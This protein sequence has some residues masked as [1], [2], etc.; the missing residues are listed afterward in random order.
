MY[1]ITIIMFRHMPASNKNPFSHIS[2]LLISITCQLYTVVWSEHVPALIMK[3]GL[4]EVWNVYC[5]NKVWVK[6][7]SDV[8][9]KCLLRMPDAVCTNV[10]QDEKC[11]NRSFK[12]KSYILIKTQADNMYAPT[13]PLQYQIYSS[14][15]LQFNCIEKQVTYT[16]TR[17][18]HIAHIHNM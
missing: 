17:N 12:I 9:G 3:R 13:T 14:T 10:W 18:Y 4:M 7:V 2:I 1:I 16:T 8:K 6:S 5:I 11:L 15:R